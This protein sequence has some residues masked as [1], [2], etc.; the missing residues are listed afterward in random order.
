MSGIM[1]LTQSFIR[2]GF[3]KTSLHFSMKHFKRM[4]KLIMSKITLKYLKVIS[5]YK[6]S[7]I[8]RNENCHFL[9][10]FADFIAE[11]MRQ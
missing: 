10:H 8:V 4:Y 7:E 11:K 2:G 9:F 3:I 1:I 5:P 6:Y